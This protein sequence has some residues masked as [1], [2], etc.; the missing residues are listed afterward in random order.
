[1]VA[2]AVPHVG[3]VDRGPQVIHIVWTEQKD[4]KHTNTYVG[5]IVE[6]ARDS[7][8]QRHANRGGSWTE[9]RRAVCELWWMDLTTCGVSAIPEAVICQI[10][11]T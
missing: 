8:R 3:T 4:L 7:M 11:E 2:H 10:H 1:M 5:Y 6:E 9:V